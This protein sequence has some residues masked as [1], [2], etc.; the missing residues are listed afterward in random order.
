MLPLFWA[1]KFWLNT[2]IYQY[3]SVERVPTMRNQTVPISN[4]KKKTTANGKCT[5]STYFYMEY[6]LPT[7]QFKPD[8]I[9]SIAM[10]LNMCMK[11]NMRMK[12]V[13]WMCVRY[14]THTHTHIVEGFW[15]KLTVKMRAADVHSNCDA[16]SMLISLMYVQITEKLINKLFLAF[17]MIRHWRAPH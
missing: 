6:G 17:V 9:D 1:I 7:A 4:E 11:I 16:L 3:H 5:I 14:K 2:F 12:R 8:A 10:S 13:V 15:L